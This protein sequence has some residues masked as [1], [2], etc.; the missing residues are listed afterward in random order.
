M[1]DFGGIVAERENQF[2]LEVGSVYEPAPIT[3][4]VTLQKGSDTERHS[5]STAHFNGTRFI[6]TTY[7]LSTLNGI[8]DTNTTTLNRNHRPLLH[9][10]GTFYRGKLQI[11]VNKV[12]M[13]EK[14]LGTT[15]S[16]LITLR[17]ACTSGARAVSS[18]ECLRPFRY[19]PTS[20]R[21]SSI[22]P[23]R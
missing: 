20:T 22:G 18:G 23:L 11:Y 5:I 8:H 7:P 2:K 15:P 21:R 4:T 6:G 17:G 9:V 10:I 14:E 3:F 12:L 16:Q 13:A 1:P 19:Q